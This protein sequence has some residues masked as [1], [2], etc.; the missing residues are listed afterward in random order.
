MKDASHNWYALQSTDDVVSPA[1]LV[2]PERIRKNIHLMI[3]MIGDEKRLRP[4]IKTH[5][6]AEIIRMQIEL[7]IEK[8]KCA[9]I[10]EAELLAMCGAG[11]VL[12][13]LQPVG[14]NISRFGQLIR[15]FP[16]TQFSTL[17]DCEAVVGELSAL[18]ENS[19]VIIPVFLDLNTG[20]DRTGIEVG[21]KAIQIYRAICDAPGLEAKGLHNYDGHIRHPD[22]E[23][24]RQACNN[25]FDKVLALKTELEKEQMNVQVVIAGGTPTFP[26]HSQ[27]DGVEASPGTTL[28]WDARYDSLFNDLKF[29]Q[30]AILF[31]R[32]ISKPNKDLLCLDLGHKAIAPE[33]DFPRVKLFG[34]EH[35][36]Q[37]SQSE[38]HLVVR[39][40]DT[41]SH[42]V[43]DPVYAIPMH[44]C[45]TVAKYPRLM[46]VDKG[47]ITDTWEVAARN[48][49]ITI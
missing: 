8:F 7:G 15:A 42:A 23:K 38:E 14:V 18:A 45:P 10:A 33:M 3:D 24:R 16:S 1:L 12:L 22:P 9:T 28:L 36:E 25:A 27:R 32:I 30:A 40:G 6:T 11:D 2:Y 26:I 31:C 21:E 39:C 47:V 44:I 34:L 20:M 41:S 13:A 19:S 46:V 48:Y 4:H 49:K 5:K 37:I 29:H 35:C 43:G 17:V